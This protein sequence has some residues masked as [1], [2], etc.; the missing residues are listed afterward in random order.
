MPKDKLGDTPKGDTPPED[1]LPGDTPKGD[2]PPEGD[3]PSDTPSDNF[4]TL[5]ED[6]ELNKT[7]SDPEK[8]LRALPEK[9]RTLKRL[10]MENAEFRRLLTEQA[11]RD[12]RSVPDPMSAE[13]I[14]EGLQTDPDGTLNKMGYVKR[15]DLEQVSTR[16]GQTEQSLLRDRM[17]TVL[18]QYPELKD[19]AAHCR[20]SETQFPWGQ[21]KLWD[22]MMTT[23]YSDQGLSYASVDSLIPMLYAMHTR[24]AGDGSPPPPVSPKRKHSATTTSGGGSRSPEGEQPDYSRPEWT[25]EKIKADLAKRGRAG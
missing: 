10:D 9:E 11:Q 25:P 6:L 22:S 2:N 15:S 5:M 20:H 21:N 7:Y 3:T 1:V 14:V 24:G 16:V 18:E 13:D 12:R 17:A 23:Y 19:V 8:A 4:D